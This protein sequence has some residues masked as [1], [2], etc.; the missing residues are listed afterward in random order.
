MHIALYAIVC[1]DAFQGN[2][3]RRDEPFWNICCY[4]FF[5]HNQCD[6]LDYLVIL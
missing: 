3:L 4:V 1:T 2:P 6:D 5:I